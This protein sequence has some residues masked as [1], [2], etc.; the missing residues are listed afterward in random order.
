VIGRLVE[1]QQVRAAHQ[2]LR[3]IEPHAPTA[4]ERSDRPR[5]VRSREAETVHESTSATARVITAERGVAGVQLAQC[6]AGIPRFSGGHRCFGLAQLGVAVHDELDR[7]ALRGIHF[8]RDVRDDQLGRH[9][10]AAGIGLQLAEDQ[11]Q[12][13]RLTAAVRAD[14]ADLLTAIDRERR[15]RY[16]QP[17]ATAERQSGKSKHC[18][19]VEDL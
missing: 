2:R 7:V 18:R 16:Q 15:V 17:R 6:G 10:E 5:F 11:R 13:A 19:I 4:R 8:L 14:D 1:Q 9:V 12:Q 3:Q